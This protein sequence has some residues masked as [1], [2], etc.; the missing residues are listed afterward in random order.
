[1]LIPGMQ[2]CPASAAAKLRNLEPANRRSAKSGC[3]SH[4]P[5]RSAHRDHPVSQGQSKRDGHR[6]GLCVVQSHSAR[7]RRLDTIRGL[8]LPYFGNSVQPWHLSAMQRDGPAG[9]QLFTGA[10][11]RR[12]GRPVISLQS[13]GGTFSKAS[14]VSPADN[15][16]RMNSMGD[17]GRFAGVLYL[18]RSIQG[19]FAM[20]YVPK[21]LI[22]HGNATATIR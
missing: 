12:C 2:P 5:Y 10:S 7:T 18:L 15:R 22:V 13:A 6:D 17:P 9:S 21:K 19:F 3:R 4:E 16:G 14:P 20:G 8:L 11:G 1:M